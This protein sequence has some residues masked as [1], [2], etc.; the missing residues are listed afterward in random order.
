M[1]PGLDLVRRPLQ[2]GWLRRSATL[3]GRFLGGFLGHFLGRVCGG[4]P[5]PI[6]SECIEP[7]FLLVIQQVIEFPQ[8]LLHGF[9]CLDHCPD[10][11]LHD[12]QPLRC[13]ERRPRRTGR[14]NYLRGRAQCV[15]KIV[16]SGAQRLIRL[17]R[18]SDLIDGE[19]D[20]F[21]AVIAAELL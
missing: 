13:R 21:A 18:L 5:A 2:R 19:A 7:C 4:H 1:Q 12:G 20:R 9:L 6:L 14:P 16:Q 11:L 8:R 15:G 17:Y 3:G 10:A